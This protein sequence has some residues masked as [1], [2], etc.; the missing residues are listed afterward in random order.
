MTDITTSLRTKKLLL[1]YYIYFLTDF[2]N[3]YV[4]K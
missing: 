4:N 3:D 2:L 1:I